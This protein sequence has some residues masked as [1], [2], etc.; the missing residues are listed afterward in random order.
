MIDVSKRYDVYCSEGGEEVVYRNALFR[1]TKKF[2]PRR[3]RDVSAEFM[4]I[5]QA[6]GKTI[7]IARGSI[8]KFCEHVAGTGPE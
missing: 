8:T 6:D 7:F 5:E 4:E 2:L 1:S 3:E